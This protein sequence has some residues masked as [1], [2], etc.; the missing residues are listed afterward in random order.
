MKKLLCIFLGCLLSPFLQAQS[1][2]FDC[3]H[4]RSGDCI[5]KR[6]VTACEQ[7]KV[8]YRGYGILAD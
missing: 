8:V 3:N 2:T 4:P 7:E 6:M 5:L 1:L